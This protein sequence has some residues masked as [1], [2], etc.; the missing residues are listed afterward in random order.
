MATNSRGEFYVY[1]RSGE[2]TRLFKFDASG[3]FQREIG[4]GLYGM[5]FAHAVRVDAEDNVWI[6]DEGSDMVIKFNPEGRV[7][8]TI[9]RRPE[10]QGLRETPHVERRARKHANTVLAVLPI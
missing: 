7:M 6:V 9:G 10:A 5:V 2:A 3:N 4:Y 1:T 8:M